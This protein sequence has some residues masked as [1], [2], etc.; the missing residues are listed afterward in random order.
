MPSFDPFVARGVRVYGTA[1][2]PIER[3][4]I[5]GPGWYVRIV[6]AESWSWNMAGEP[7]G[8]SWYPSRHRRH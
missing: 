8:G 4:G 7:V 1:D 3:T 5:I 2:D 6:P